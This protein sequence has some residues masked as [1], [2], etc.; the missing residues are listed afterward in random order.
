MAHS[1]DEVPPEPWRRR[2]NP[3]LTAKFLAFFLGFFHFT[4]S[5]TRCCHYVAPAIE[6]LNRRVERRRTQVHVALSH[7]EVAVAR[8]FLNGPRR[9]SMH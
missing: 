2:T 8:E 7:A 1:Q 9:C 5:T 6:Q 3:C 4:T